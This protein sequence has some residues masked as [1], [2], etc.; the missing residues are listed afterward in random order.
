[1]T[2]QQAKELLPI[3]TAFAEGKQIQCRNIS[4][5]DWLNLDY[6]P[7]F[8]LSPNQYR[9]KP[10][11]IILKYRRYIWKDHEGFYVASISQNLGEYAKI[12]K[13]SCFV[14]WI[15]NDWV[16]YECEV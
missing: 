10:D 12:E 9:I 16:T 2:P 11:T 13:M 4:N 3:L 6:D 8:C 14:R 7:V 1:M 5:T 15:D